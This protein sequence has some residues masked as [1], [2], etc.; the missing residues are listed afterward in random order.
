VALE[1][2]HRRSGAYA[3]RVYEAFG[4]K[5]S[6]WRFSRCPDI[7]TAPIILPSLDDPWLGTSIVEELDNEE[8]VTESVAGAKTAVNGKDLTSIRHVPTKRQRCADYLP[9]N[10][11]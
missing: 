10:N 4:C 3:W 11:C 7:A 6:D 8:R 5:I 9:E 2:L 1:E